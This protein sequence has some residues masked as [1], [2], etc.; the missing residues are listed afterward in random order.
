MKG[1]DNMISSVFALKEANTIPD[2]LITNTE[3]GLEENYYFNSSL[4]FLLEC[5]NELLSYRK[6]FYKFVLETG[7]ENPYIINEA[8]E[9]I[10]DK[11]KLVIKK[12]LAYIES[13]IKRFVTALNKFVSSDKYII[14]MK[15]EINKF[16]K[17]KS[18]T[19][20][21]YHYTIN[22]KVPVIDI[23]GLD[24][25]HVQTAINSIGDKDDIDS[26]LNALADQLT[27]F[28][29][30][31]G[32]SNARSQILNVTYDISESS[33]ANEVFS[34]YRDGKA[35]ESDI[36]IYKEDV[37]KALSSFEGY[38]DKIKQVNNLRSS[39]IS[40]YKALESQVDSILKENFNTKINNSNDTKVRTS[41][42]NHLNVL[43]SP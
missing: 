20:S 21:G 4:D 29:S 26:Q 28:T 6:D 16:P 11:V 19:I 25:T 7:D 42:V 14:N 1:E 13:I 15:K 38:K 10:I 40:K 35:E 12:I 36:D 5:Q 23:V 17:D 2:Y 30:E 33:F 18:F 22:D 24:L 27:Q 9:D 41:L 32:L 39:I 3:T 8:F 31:S 37:N 43:I 34:T